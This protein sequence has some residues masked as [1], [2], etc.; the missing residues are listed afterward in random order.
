MT[1]IAAIFAPG[2][3]R[4][5]QL[6]RM[7]AAMGDRV[8]DARGV[9]MKAPFALG[10]LV[11]HTTAESLEATQPLANEDESLAVV[12]DGYLTNY[13]E[14]RSDL[15]ARGAVLRSRSDAELVLRAYEQWGE[16][17]A[18]RIEGEYAFVIADTRA[19]RIYAARDPKGL[20]PLHVYEDGEALLFASDIRGLIKGAT[21]RPSPNPDYLA[22]IAAGVWH[23]R[24]AT[25]WQGVDRVPQAHWLSFDGRRRK[26]VRFYDLPTTVTQRYRRE[27]DYVEH[28]RAVLFDAVRRTSRS[29]RPLAVALSGGLDSSGVLGVAH[30]L[31][32][33]GR[34]PAPGIE[35][36]TLAGE[37]GSPA[38]ELPY[39]RA[40]A[41]HC[42]ISCHEVPLFRPDIAWFDA[43]GRADCDV[44]VPQNGAMSRDL[45][46]L[47]YAN[48]SRAFLTGSG[49]DEWLDGTPLYYRQLARE[50]DLRG[51]LAALVR[52]GRALGWKAAAERALRPTIGAVLSPGMRTKRREQT[53]RRRLDDPDYLFWMQPAWRE[54]LTEQEIDFVRSL[55]EEADGMSRWGRLFSPY[56]AFANTV[57]AGQVAKAGLETRNPMLTRG[58]IEFAAT[59]PEWIRNQGS[60]TKVIHRKA[61]DGI[62][63]SVVLERRSKAHFNSPGITEQ[64]AK[65]VIN[66][67]ASW[68]EPFCELGQLP[69]LTA[70]YGDLPVDPDK[71]WE[72]WGLYAV[73][74]FCM[75][76]DD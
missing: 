72:L 32:S 48:G 57:V 52:D 4:L 75:R 67:T 19:N 56:P 74:A 60:V 76:A 23:L 38:F 50:G 47:A 34:L 59:T 61:L 6:D 10:A 2:P 9:W 36:Y 71:A 11:L 13:E 18:G 58:F 69:R 26:C 53:I 27:E 15:L 25:V 28:Y 5:A 64:F 41:E 46:M 7:M 68:L 3:A 14:L 30:R 12:I 37:P 63:P 22:N 8:H 35:A 40:V 42:G 39:A 20:R 33:K 16:D 31:A 29:H 55:P 44:A 43:Q 21:R 51:Y 49:G 70:Q 17:C 45:E 54:R 24:D 65:G 62:V 73:A 66:Q 1:G